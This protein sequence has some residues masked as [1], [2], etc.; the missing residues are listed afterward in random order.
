MLQTLFEDWLSS[1]QDWSQSSTFINAME[2]ATLK[3]R[4]KH[5]Y[6]TLKQLKEQ[7]GA[8][9]ALEIKSRKLELER[10]RKAG[11]MPY[12]QKHPEVQNDEDSGVID[13]RYHLTFNVDGA[14]HHPQNHEFEILLRFKIKTTFLPPLDLFTQYI[15]KQWWILAGHFCGNSFSYNI[16]CET[17]FLL[18][19]TVPLIN[20]NLF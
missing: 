17:I 18:W 4:G 2:S 3:K 15:C 10:T 16:C 19:R 7:Y 13:L 12:F 5:V 11:E 6:R 9:L 14:G 1:G 8:P 20:K